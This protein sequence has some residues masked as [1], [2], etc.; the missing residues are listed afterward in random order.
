MRNLKLT[1]QRDL[2]WQI[3]LCWGFSL[4]SSFLDGVKLV[5][6]VFELSSCLVLP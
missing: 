2:P 3:S 5:P 1:F 4:P 6:E